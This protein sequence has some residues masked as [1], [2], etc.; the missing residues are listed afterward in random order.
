MVDYRTYRG[1][2]NVAVAA[3]SALNFFREVR[4]E[5]LK[6]KDRG[7]EG[8]M[9]L[10]RGEAGATTNRQYGEIDVAEGVDGVELLEA[11]KRTQ[12]LI[13]PAVVSSADSGASSNSNYVNEEDD[14][15]GWEVCSADDDEDGANDDG[16]WVTVEHSDDEEG[17]T[18][19]SSSAVIT[20]VS[21]SAAAG[22]IKRDQRDRLDAKKILTPRDFELLEQLKAER[23]QLGK[24]KRRAADHYAAEAM[25]RTNNLAKASV[26]DPLTLEGPHA[27]RKRGLEERLRTMREGQMGRDSNVPGRKAGMSNREKEKRTKNFM[28]I[29]KKRSVLMKQK[30]SLRQVRAKVN[31]HRAHLKKNTKTITKIRSRRRQGR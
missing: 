30:Q 7:K 16:D 10:S 19:E 24:R 26:V 11:H 28:M 21:E 9:A 17:D 15:E 5:L 22:T 3:R 1:D 27:I 13:N 14:D 23:A 29:S 25:L 4:P 31:K 8:S 18:F 2:K 12:A 20:A 6:R